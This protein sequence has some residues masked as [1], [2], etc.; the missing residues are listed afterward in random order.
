[1]LMPNPLSSPTPPPFTGRFLDDIVKVHEVHL[2][3][4]FIGN[5]TKLQEAV[6]K[7]YM[8]NEVYVIL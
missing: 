6:L 1:M 7:E 8:K 5:E 4:M 3:K 2:F